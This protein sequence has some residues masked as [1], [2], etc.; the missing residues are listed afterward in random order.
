[1]S[2]ANANMVAANQDKASNKNLPKLKEDGSNYKPYAIKLRDY[3]EAIGV[4]KAFN[5]TIPNPDDLEEFIEANIL[6]DKKHSSYI[7]GLTADEFDQSQPEL[8]RDDDDDGK[9]I[10]LQANARSALVNSLHDDLVYIIENASRHPA[11]YLSKIREEFEPQD[12]TSLDHLYDKMTL[13]D[14]RNYKSFEKC[15]SDLLLTTQKLRQAGQTVEDRYVLNTLLKGLKPDEKFKNIKP[16][17]RHNKK[18][19]VVNALKI[20]KAE[21]RSTGSLLPDNSSTKHSPDSNDPTQKPKQELTSIMKLLESKINNINSRLSNINKNYKHNTPWKN[22]RKTYQ[23][24]DKNNNQHYKKQKKDLECWNCG[25]KG[26]LKKDCFFLNKNKKDY[27]N[28]TNKLSEMIKNYQGND[29]VPS[30]KL[31]MLQSQSHTHYKQNNTK[32]Q[33]QALIDSGANNHHFK[34]KFWFTNL[35]RTPERRVILANG[36]SF[37]VEYSGTVVL[38]VN[39]PSVDP[40][41]K[42]VLHNALYSPNLDD[43]ILSAAALARQGYQTTINSKAVTINGERKSKFYAV[44]TMGHDG[45]PY[46]SIRP[47]PR[48]SICKLRNTHLLHIKWDISAHKVYAKPQRSR[49]A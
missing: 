40:N 20:I 1:M 26:H 38:F 23:Q 46:L 4:T 33:G 8:D 22:K 45:L 9:L 41:N 44:A 11:H 3:L 29:R 7:S 18:I 42:M 32:L 16:L 47:H 19:T 6:L 27:R 13:F 37:D 28:K 31:Y 14:V 43:N 30:N 48:S 25:K 21:L 12:I 17:I 5:V 35:K 2:S 39:E 49:M 36:N 15:A 10:K 34:N 24:N